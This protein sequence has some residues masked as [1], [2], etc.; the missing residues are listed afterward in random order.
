L[1][2]LE[3]QNGQT[4]QFVHGDGEV[5]IDNSVHRLAR[6]GIFNSSGC[7]SLRDKRKVIS[8]SFGLMSR[9]GYQRDFINP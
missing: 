6:M 2:S 5:H 3:I 1:H 8:T 7:P 9:A 4:A